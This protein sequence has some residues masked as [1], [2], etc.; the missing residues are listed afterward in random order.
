MRH[1]RQEQHVAG[2]TKSWLFR[3]QCRHRRI[4]FAQC[5]IKFTDA[6]VPVGVL[7]QIVLANLDVDSQQCFC[8]RHAFFVR[9]FNCELA[10]GGQ[11]MNIVGRK[12][13]IC[14]ARQQP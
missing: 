9:A 8:R 5:L 3:Q 6:V 12:R 11:S 10:N 13:G 1:L 2:F 7:F 14:D 4:D